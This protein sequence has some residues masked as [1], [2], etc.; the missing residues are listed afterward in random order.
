MAGRWC[1]PSPSTCWRRIMARKSIAAP[2]A[3]DADGGDRSGPRVTRGPDRPWCVRSVAG[4][5]TPGRASGAHQVLLQGRVRG[6]GV[7]VGVVEGRVPLTGEEP[8]HPGV[9][10]VHVPDG[11]GDAVAHREARLELLVE[12]ERLGE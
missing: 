2:S 7:E 9:G 10:V 8:R 5:W 3:G 6:L 1:R 4:T 12:L 11:E